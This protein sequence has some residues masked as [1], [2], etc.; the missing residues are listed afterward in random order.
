MCV[1]YMYVVCVYFV[2]CTNYCAR[3]VAVCHRRTGEWWYYGGGVMLL[4]LLL[5]RLCS[6]A[7]LLS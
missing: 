3:A 7:L 2:L 6:F 4:L 5:M 1:C